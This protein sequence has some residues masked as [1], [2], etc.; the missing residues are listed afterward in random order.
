MEKGRKFSLKRGQPRK[1]RREKCGKSGRFGQVP[2]EFV[3]AKARIQTFGPGLAIPPLRFTKQIHQFRMLVDASAFKTKTNLTGSQIKGAAAAY[4]FAFNW[5]AVDMPFNFGS[6]FDQ[7][8]LTRIVLRITSSK[9]TNVTGVGSILYVVEDYDN[10]TL[11]T[12]A[13]QAETYEN[14]QKIRG[15]DA[16]EGESVI[17]TLQPTVPVPSILGNTILTSPW[18]DLAVTNNSHYGVKGWYAT[19]ANTDPVWDVDAQYWIECRNTQ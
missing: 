2:E 14:C 10:S 4:G 5:S 3:R 12:S 13:A 8:R 17:I 18:Q 15:S 19:V 1:A 9:N 11:L 7:F 6:L 16:G